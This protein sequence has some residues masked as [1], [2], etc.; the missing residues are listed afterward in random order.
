MFAETAL[1]LLEC[2]Q[3]RQ[4]TLALH[5]IHNSVMVTEMDASYP[6]GC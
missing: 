2:M 6:C 3:L 5:S 1:N 4:D